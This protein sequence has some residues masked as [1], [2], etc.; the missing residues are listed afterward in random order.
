MY[1]IFFCIIFRI[2]DIHKMNMKLIQIGKFSTCYLSTLYHPKK[3]PLVLLFQSD[4]F[5]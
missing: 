1:I 2:L 4:V 5:P 3:L